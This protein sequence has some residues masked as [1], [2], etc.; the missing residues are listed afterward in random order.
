MIRIAVTGG[1]ACGKSRFAETLRKL[2]VETLDADDIVHELVPEEER[3]RLAKVAFRDAKV[4][5]ELEARLHPLVAER[6]D[7]WFGEEGIGKREEGIGKREEGMGKREEGM[8][9]RE[10]GIGKREEVRLKQEEDKPLASSLLPIPCKI[11]IIPLLFEVHWEKKYDI[12]CAVICSKEK[13]IERMM[14][15]RGLTRQ[16]AED[17]LA[18]Q[19]PTDEKA[20]KSHYVIRNE[21]TIEELERQAAEFVSWLEEIKNKENKEK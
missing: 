8:G 11:A 10:K 9:K 12:I 3:R 21:G 17:R 16:E 7:R 20:A 14:Q 5:A 1:I 2:G 4:R 19:M 13:Q 6:F 15:R 18:A